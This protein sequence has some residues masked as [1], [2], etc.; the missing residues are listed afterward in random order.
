MEFRQLQHFV[1]VAEAGHFSH[2]ADELNISQSGLSA[3]VRALE[4]AL[5]VPVFERT[6][7]SVVLTAAG[8]TLLGHARRILREVEATEA[9]LAA[10]RDA[11]AGTLAIG[12]VQ[13][14]TAVDL[15]AAIARLHAGHPRV[16]MLL[17][18]APTADLL[19]AVDDGELDLAF[20]ALDATPLPAGL[21]A[22][23][24]YPE[25]LVVVVGAEHPLAN[26]GPVRLADLADQP[27]VEF[28][29]GLGLQTVV[30]ALFR[31]AGVPRQIAFRT[32][33]MEQA[34]SLVGHG[35][36]VAVVPEPVARRS[37]L[38]VLQLG[39][40]GDDGTPPVRRLALVGRTT[41]PTNPAA[42]AF[43]ALVPA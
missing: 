18:E 31:D 29:A 1:A 42:R 5:A 40:V 16:Q 11:Q 25:T 23:R 24:D 41:V 35:L 9:S 26:R 28:Q 17:R 43:L 19:A 8:R 7:R 30:A 4:R 39:P 34:L 22:L 27:F 36:G 21:I 2:A 37:G 6:T 20:V 33:Q 14:F 3:S 38:P 15:P 13:T 12:V 32:S 10:V